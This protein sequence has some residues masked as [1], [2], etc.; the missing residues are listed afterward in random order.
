MSL[1]FIV[2]RSFCALILL[3]LFLVSPASAQEQVI[4]EIVAVVADKIVL[5][6]DVDALVLGIL[7]QQRAPYSDALWVE[8]LNQLI[9]Q[10][11]LAEHARRD[12]NITVTDDQ[13][14]QSID[15]RISVLTEQV[16]SVTRLEEIY[17]QS[18]E[19]IRED[20]RPSFRERLMAEQFQNTKLKT[21][22][23][24]PSEVREWFAQFP[25][26]SLPTLPTVIRA[27]HIVQYPEV[28]KEAEEE[29]LEIVSAIRDSIE[30][31]R[32]TLEE[33]A[34]RYSEDVGSANNGGRYEAM[35][36]ADLVPEFAAVAARATPGE[37]SAPFKSPFGFHILRVNSRVGDQVDFSHVLINIDKSKSD[38][39]EAIEMLNTLRDSLLTSEVPFELL[40]RRHSEEKST[41]EIGGRIVDP[42]TGE[43]DL[44]LEALGEAWQNLADTLEIGE[45][46]LPGPVAL[47]DGTLGYHI[48]QLQRLI[49]EHRVDID[50][51]GAR[52]E[53]LALNDK[54]NIEMRK[55]L[56]SLRD[57]V[58]VE[59]RGR[60]LEL[61]SAAQHSAGN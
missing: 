55:W 51:D 61:F 2:R 4:D 23:V 21:I 3:P 6:S 14:G 22:T 18:V 32:S 16:G 13:V 47:L 43:R 41:S 11:V 15:Q 5:R 60:G 53:Q 35:A 40:A 26:D 49:P 58:Y 9:D 50:T 56:D 8:S 54:R 7:Q 34:R 52:I 33:L 48:V 24:T 19:E 39:S 12:T 42:Q 36:L 28:S 38:P 45:I 29:A 27:S 10:G 57:E 20:L 1:L 44:F 17:G 30:A 37:L 46:S 31:G 59:L 25:T